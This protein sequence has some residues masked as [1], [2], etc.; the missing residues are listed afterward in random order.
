MARNYRAWIW[1]MLSVMSY[2]WLGASTIWSNVYVIIRMIIFNQHSCCCSA[3]KSCPTLQPYGLQ[4]AMLPCLS[5]SP[6]F[7]QTHVRWVSGYHPTI[8]SSAACFSCR[9]QSFPASG[10]FPMTWPLASG[11]QSTGASGS[12]SVFPMNI[13]GWFPLGL[14]GLFWLQSKGISRVFCSTTSPVWKH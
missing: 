2:L 11:G 5:L 7:A 9:L 6:E 12:A 8:S 1:N 4:H 13:Q 14:T 10:S 3:A